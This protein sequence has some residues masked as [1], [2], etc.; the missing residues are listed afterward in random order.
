MLYVFLVT[1]LA[2]GAA[3]QTIPAPQIWTDK[4]LAGWANPVAT[5]TCR[6]PTS[7]SANIMPRSPANGSARIRFTSRAGN[8]KAIGSMLRN[9]KPE[10]IITPGARSKAEWIRAGQIVFRELDVSAFRTYDPGD[11]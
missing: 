1:L 7:Q 8:L 4:D 2:A 5:L 10:P 11:L 9:K 3:A 6:P